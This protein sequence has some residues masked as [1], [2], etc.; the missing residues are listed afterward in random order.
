MK[1]KTH[2]CRKPRSVCVLWLASQSLLGPYGPRLVDFIELF[3]MLLT[4]FAPGILSLPLTQEPSRS[5][6]CLPGCRYICFNHL[7]GEAFL[8]AFMLGSCLSVYQNTI[9]SVRGGL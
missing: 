5:T 6:Y 7:L 1:T 4:S 2:M 8:V 3:V 9:N